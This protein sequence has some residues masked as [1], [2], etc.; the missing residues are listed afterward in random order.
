V[1]PVLAIVCLLCAVA[2]AEEIPADPTAARERLTALLEA[3][4][5]SEALR[6]A[7]AA[8]AVHPERAELHYMYGMMLLGVY[9][10]PAAIAE[11]EAAATLLPGEDVSYEDLALAYHLA[12]DAAQTRATL[13]KLP[14]DNRKR[15]GILAELARREALAERRAPDAGPIPAFVDQTI[16]RLAAGDADAVLAAIDPKL[17]DERAAAARREVAEVRA[18]VKTLVP[19]VAPAILGWQVD[20]TPRQA[21]GDP[22]TDV[23]V[24]LLVRRTLSRGDF[25][26]VLAQPGEI[27]PGLEKL[28]PA[29]RRAVLERLATRPR[30]YVVRATVSLRAVE[31]GWR[32]HDARA[33]LD[34]AQSL[35]GLLSLPVAAARPIEAPPSRP[36]GPLVVIAVAAVLLGGGLLLW[37]RRRR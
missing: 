4:Q 23:D 28:E 10:Y 26:T 7:D 14:E 21:A 12:G 22:D 27:M 8:I 2:R 34:V 37:R 20:G 19:L 29:D 25:E 32:I 11:L 5:Q 31:G 33:R 13:A 9:D 16:R 6:F 1:R 17:L 18:V 3:D 35:I 36:I 15:Q 24:T 30:E